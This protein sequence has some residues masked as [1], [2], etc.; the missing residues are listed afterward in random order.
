MIINILFRKL[1]RILIKPFIRE[2]LFDYSQNKT[3]LSINK[4][5][6]NQ[7]E[8]NNYIFKELKKD[9]PIM[10]SR[11]GYTELN[12]IFR[13]DNYKRMHYLEKIYNWAQTSQYPFS[14]NCR[15]NNIDKLSG[16][17]PVSKKNL[18]LFKLEMINSMKEIDLLGSWV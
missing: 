15:L 5:Y 4:K 3:L 13:F 10:I 17:F 16:F 7:E 12:T 14:K 8:V 2:E 1:I 9:K 18:S 11:F 6:L